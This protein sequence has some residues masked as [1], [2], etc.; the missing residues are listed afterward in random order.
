MASSAICAVADCGKRSHRLSYCRAHYERFRR[1]GDPQ[2]GRTADGEPFRW[3][4]RHKGHV[5][6]GCLT[7]PF[8]R[9]SGT[10]GR[11]RSSGNGPTIYAHREMCRLAHG[12]PP[13][14][15]H[16]ATHSCG[17]GHLGCVNPRHLR[18]ATNEENCADKKLHGT[19]NTGERNGRSKLT[20]ENVREIRRLSAGLSQ[21]QI[22]ERFGVSR[23]AVSDV[24]SGRRWGWLL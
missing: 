21:T 19:E 9:R 20:E 6:D 7:W 13:T 10:Y 2:G 1:H 16:Q 5:A 23:A 8:A 17:N 15:L 11:F 24:V 3:L 4:E 14:D 22:A 12:Q 18:W